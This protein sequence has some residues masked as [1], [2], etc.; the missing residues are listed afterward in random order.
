MFKGLKQLTKRKRF[1]INLHLFDKDL[2]NIKALLQTGPISPDD[3]GWWTEK[4]ALSS[5]IK[6]PN[7]IVGEALVVH[8]SYSTKMKEMLRLNLL[9]EFE[10]VFKMELGAKLNQVLWDAFGFEFLL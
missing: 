5:E 7:C 3:E 6:Q 4:Y 2:I 8:F 10:T 9:E 1:S